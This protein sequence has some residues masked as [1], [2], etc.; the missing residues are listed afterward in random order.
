MSRAAGLTA[1]KLGRMKVT[2]EH[3]WRA[4][5]LP[6]KEDGE[7]PGEPGLPPSA[8]FARTHGNG[9]R[10]PASSRHIC[11]ISQPFKPGPPSDEG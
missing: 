9:E 7:G 11:G 10:A 6:Q 4:I 1:D 3:S 8:F 5:C 2:P